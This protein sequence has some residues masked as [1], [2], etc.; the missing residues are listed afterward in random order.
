MGDHVTLGHTY[1]NSEV[2]WEI[3]D[4]IKKR[5]YAITMNNDLYIRQHMIMW[6]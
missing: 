4:M 6:L 1:V 5:S 2:I 3:K